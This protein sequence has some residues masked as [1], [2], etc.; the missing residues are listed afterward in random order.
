MI[1]QEEKEARMRQQLL[2]HHSHDSAIDAD[3]QE[4][5]MEMVALETDMVRQNNF[6]VVGS[7]TFL[8]TFKSV[9]KPWGGGGGGV[10]LTK[11]CYPP[12]STNL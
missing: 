5:Q 9:L 6:R 8:I 10:T 3:S 1:Q 7:L 2:A 12:I 4:W 11:V